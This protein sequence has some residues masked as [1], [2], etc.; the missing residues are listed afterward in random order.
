M[1][2]RRR[3]QQTRGQKVLQTMNNLW[4]NHRAAMLAALAVGVIAVGIGGYLTFKRPADV[5]NEDAFF[6]ETE[7]TKQLRF[8]D[9]PFYRL[10]PERTGYLAAD[11][12]KPPYRV[13]WSFK[14]RSLLEYAPVLYK[15]TLF[16]VNKNGQF[17]SID[18]DN[19][20]KRYEIDLARLNASSPAFADGLLFVANLEPSQVT[21]IHHKT[22][23][24]VWQRELPGRTESS[25]VV[26]D[27]K[28]IVGCECGTLYAFDR[29]TGR[30]LWERDLGGEI[31]AAPAASQGVIYVGTYGGDFFA[32]RA[33]DGSIKWEA[34]AQGGAFGQAGAFYA[35]AAVAFGRVYVGS[36]DSR[37]YSFEKETGELAWSHSTDDEVYVAPAAADTPNTEPT[38]YIASLNGTFYALDAR[39]G[40]ERWSDHAGGKV[41][42]A[43][44]V[45]GEVVY[46]ANLDNTETVGYN[47][48]NGDRVFNFRDGA[49]TPVISDGNRIYLTG[50]E[51]IYG[52]RPATDA[53][54]KAKEA[55]A[56]AKAA[57]PAPATKKPAKKK[58]KKKKAKK[59]K[60]KGK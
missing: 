37:V 3:S 43:P 10:N 39:N 51:R 13:R 46:V 30:T 21:A 17:F 32:V 28:V 45:I 34:G 38:I 36:K 9:W 54:I 15:D 25:P 24:V 19:G 6:S 47:V 7:A 26:L 44:S 56:A 48:T 23:T 60:K 27:K 18:A 55:A 16:T 49:Y 42:G 8:G 58:K 33:N 11:G 53:E 20:K 4:T 22:G 1:R 14:G 31:K 2:F 59:G 40:D 5:T 35:T 12:V 41:I 57:A 52:L 50:R 29:E